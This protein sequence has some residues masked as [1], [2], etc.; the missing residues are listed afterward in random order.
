MRTYTDT[1]T[2]THTPFSPAPPSHLTFWNISKCI[3]KDAPGGRRMP[4][5]HKAR[6]QKI[7]SRKMLLCAAGFRDWRLQSVPIINNPMGD[8]YSNA[9]QTPNLF[10]RRG[11]FTQAQ[12]FHWGP[13]CPQTLFPWLK[14]VCLSHNKSCQ[15]IKNWYISGGERARRGD[16]TLGFYDF[17]LKE[18]VGRDNCWCLCIQINLIVSNFIFCFI[19]FHPW[20]KRSPCSS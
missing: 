20:P 11:L 18:N 1:Q 4:H 6:S 7:H 5:F 8:P 19:F 10:F 15:L 2:H 16:R 3:I 9:A 13:K 14:G 17:P 12:Q